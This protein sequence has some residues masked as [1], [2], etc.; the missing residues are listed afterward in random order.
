MNAVGGILGVCDLIAIPHRVG[1]TEDG[2]LE[3]MLRDYED[4]GL[5]KIPKVLILNEIE[6][7]S[8]NLVVRFLSGRLRQEATLVESLKTFARERGL[9][10]VSF[11]KSLDCQRLML[12]GIS[13]WEQ[14]GKK[15]KMYKT[16]RICQDLSVVVAALGI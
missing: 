2:R 13:P 1:G 11:C 5:G 10:V 7:L 9:P 3:A 15:T 8:S 14:H 16:L 12:L 6:S 4:A